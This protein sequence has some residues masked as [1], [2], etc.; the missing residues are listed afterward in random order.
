[1]AQ[2]IKL[3]D[4]ISRYE[5]DIYRYSGQFIRLKQER[6]REL[7]ETWESGRSERYNETSNLIQL[8][9][10]FQSDIYTFQL[11]WASST[12]YERSKIKHELLEDKDLKFLITELPDSYLVMYHPVFRVKHAPVEAEIILISP[13]KIY[14]IA[15]LQG[16][17]NTI[18]KALPGKFWEEYSQTKTIKHLN[19]M[20]SIQR[21]SHLVKG[22]L[23]K[24]NCSFP[25]SYLILS[26]N[27][28]VETPLD[29]TVEVIDRRKIEQWHSNLVKRLSPVK[30]VQLKAAEALLK[31][32][33]VTSYQRID[34]EQDESS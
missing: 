34:W 4:C 14:C 18:I 16:Q 6:W 11:K 32:C 28:F 20:L 26:P 13:M 23:Q 1:M 7:K 29:L 10:E 8:R 22:I 31:D 3:D 19:P 17:D 5:Q 15:V 25:V 12:V 2:L 27:S 24:Y 33:D 9:K 30:H 21:M